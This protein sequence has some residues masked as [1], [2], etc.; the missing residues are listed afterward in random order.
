MIVV[1]SGEGATDIG[2]CKDSRGVCEGNNYVPG[3]MAQIVDLMLAG[4]WG[5]SPLKTGKMICVTKKELGLLCRDV[6]STEKK[7]GR[8]K[9][10]PGKKKTQGTG[11]FFTNAIALA[12]L[13]KAQE[14]K[15]HC[16]AVAI[17]FRDTDGTRSAE[18]GR[19][20]KKVE[21]MML[22]YA[23]AKFP[24]GVPMV[25]KPKS[26]VWLLCA[27]QKQA[28]QSCARLEEISGNDD[29]KNPAKQQLADAL[30]LQKKTHRDVPDLIATGGFDPSR[31]DMPSFKEFRQRLEEVGR[32]TLAAPAK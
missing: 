30:A 25:P 10:I 28:Y 8:L 26:E 7:Q 9:S 15:H 11:E 16:L 20:E 5:D 32:A 24:R 3:A 4:L 14:V 22:G 31:I 21:S 1:I 12:N 18:R 29:S 23:T 19:W 13:A 17:L 27:F 2:G 6:T